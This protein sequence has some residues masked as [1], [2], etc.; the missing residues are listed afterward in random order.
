MGCQYFVYD[1]D[2]MRMKSYI[3]KRTRYNVTVMTKGGNLDKKNIL[4]N[5]FQYSQ[6]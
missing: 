1:M 5:A 6:Y 4:S 2:D 3:S